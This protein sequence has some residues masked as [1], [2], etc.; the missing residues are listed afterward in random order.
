M[1]NDAVARVLLALRPTCQAMLGGLSAEQI[2]NLVTYFFML[3]GGNPVLSML[4]IG[5]VVT[6]SQSRA[7][8]LNVSNLR[9]QQLAAENQRLA[10]ENHRLA[11]KN[12]RLI[13]GKAKA[14]RLAA[15]VLADD[16]DRDDSNSYK[17]MRPNEMAE[18]EGAT[19]A[20]TAVQPGSAAGPSI[21]AT[22]T[23]ATSSATTP[24]STASTSAA[25]ASTIT[26]SWPSSGATSP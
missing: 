5:H 16:S 14:R 2:L 8:L 20:T 9:N 13:S 4:L 15:L 17:R 22:H 26:I 12:Q 24:S 21:T 23:P 25:T 6:E 18:G 11:A 10:A 7:L 19:T 3:T 1:G